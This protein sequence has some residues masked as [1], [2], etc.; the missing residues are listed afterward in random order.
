MFYEPNL[1]TKNYGKFRVREKQEVSKCFRKRVEIWRKIRMKSPTIGSTDI[2]IPVYNAFEELKLCLASIYEY[3]DLKKN[4]LILIDDN[5]TDQRIGEYLDGQCAENIIVIHNKQNQG[6]S[7]NINL[8]F[9]QS[10]TR[11][12]MLLNSDTIVTER[13]VEKIAACAYSDR[14]IGTVTPLSNHATICSVPRFCEDNLLPEGMDVRRIAAIVEACSLVKYPRITVANG[15]CM[16]IKREVISLIGG[17]DAKT[18]ERGYGEENDF[19][20]RAEQMGYIHVM[21]DNTYIYH[22]GTKSFDSAEK[23][24]Y[25]RLHDSILQK[26]YPVQMK[27]NMEYCAANPNG[28]IGRNIDVALHILNGRRNIFFLLQSDFRPD[29][30][31]YAGGT[32]LHVK[33]LCQEL[34]KDNN[35]IV[36]ARDGSFLQVTVYAG[37]AS[38]TF[39]YLIGERSDFP[40]IHDRTMA[41]LFEKLLKVFSIDLVHVH[42]VS[43]TSFDIFFEAYRLGIP[44]Y[45]TLHDFYCLCPM[46]KLLNTVDSYCQ[47]K[48]GA[49][50]QACLRK[51]AG[52]YEGELFL[53]YWRKK[54]EEAFAICKKIIVPSQSAKDLVSV[55]FP[56]YIDKMA[57][58]SHGIDRHEKQA[59]A[60]GQVTI[61]ED[62]EWEIKKTEKNSPCV[63]ITGR[64]KLDGHSAHC[65]KTLLQITDAKGKQYRLP[66][67]YDRSLNISETEK[68]FCCYLPNRWSAD[69]EL[70]V[71]PYIVADG[72]CY[73]SRQQEYKI[74]GTGSGAKTKFKVAFIGGINKEKGGQVITEVIKHG[75]ASIEWYV[76]GEIGYAPLAALSRRNLVKTGFYM[77]ED[78]GSLLKYHDIDVVCILSI[79]PETF[80]YT[81]SE[82]VLYGIPVIV[83]NMGALKERVEAYGFGVAVDLYGQGVCSRIQRILEN[84]MQDRDSYQVYRNR[85]EEYVHKSVQEMADEYRRLYSSVRSCGIRDSSV[86]ERR[87]V[88]GGYRLTGQSWD[89]GRECLQDQIH[90]LER[91]LNLI[92][93]SMTFQI[94]RCLAKIPVPFKEKLRNWLMKKT[95][96]LWRT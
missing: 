33:H 41:R 20:C 78:I 31:D 6:F 7:A 63:K 39:R 36:A 19:C 94:A 88:Y 69:G 71:R 22:S 73:T 77:Q 30:K 40:V 23:Q 60:D 42:H 57:V 10:Q 29:T 12:V 8:G 45:Y 65:K 1:Y 85:A 56:D 74:P 90:V 52:I 86:R 49:E 81:L 55:Y 16:F 87:S 53:Q 28:W 54:S 37:D 95:D 67:Q 43:S 66:V 50:C 84:W 51:K 27:K 48:L 91:Q 80:S 75:D 64:A 14:S 26:R 17:F 59:Q 5:S 76:F 15:F 11:D 9:S 46:E 3:T 47:A 89:D 2:I 79:W 13:W 44:V 32:Q 62:M 34:K 35:V 93:N 72:V 18:F 70:Y 61:C 24:R 21:C 92:E 58:H 96:M 38:Y 82:A 83:S 4:R 25:I 68:R